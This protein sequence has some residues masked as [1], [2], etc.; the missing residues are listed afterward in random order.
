MLQNA[1][2]PANGG[3]W[4]VVLIR[5]PIRSITDFVFPAPNQG[6]KRYSPAAFVAR[7]RL[8]WHQLTQCVAARCGEEAALEQEPLL[9]ALA[10]TI[11][12][13]SARAVLRRV[14]G[15]E[16]QAAAALLPGP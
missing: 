16:V 7:R 4:V 3:E 14:F 15:P 10:I 13:E 8:G 9:Q 11:Q 6:S 2:Q 1:S 12:R 5:A